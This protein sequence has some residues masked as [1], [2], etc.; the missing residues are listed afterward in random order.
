MVHTDNLLG[1]VLNFYSAKQHLELGKIYVFFKNW[2]YI[3]EMLSNY[4]Q[5]EVLLVNCI[6]EK[7]ETLLSNFVL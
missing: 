6:R 4:F 5:E 1:W 2:Y 3:I 7:R